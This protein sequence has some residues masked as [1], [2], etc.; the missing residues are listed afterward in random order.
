MVSMIYLESDTGSRL[1]RFALSTVRAVRISKLGDDS[2]KFGRS[3]DLEVQV[4][5]MFT[6]VG[7]NY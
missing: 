3:S 4:I 7:K 1:S 5:E 6:L 2:V